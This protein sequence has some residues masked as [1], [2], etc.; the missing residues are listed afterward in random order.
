MSHT[1]QGGLATVVRAAAAADDR[2]C[3]PQGDS[4]REQVLRTPVDRAR[5]G[6][7]AAFG[8]LVREVGDWALAMTADGG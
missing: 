7:E 1:A 8:A 6:D 5:L 4:R 2:D 3:C